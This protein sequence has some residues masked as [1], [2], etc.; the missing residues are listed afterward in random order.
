MKDGDTLYS[1]ICTHASDTH[2]MV[3][4]QWNLSI[5]DTWTKGHCELIYIQN[6]MLQYHNQAVEPSLHARLGFLPS[7]PLGWPCLGL[8]V[9]CASFRECQPHNGTSDSKEESTDH[10]MKTWVG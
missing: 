8:G 5:K 6:K 10:E 1:L 3:Y 4:A 7:S 9:V 2:V